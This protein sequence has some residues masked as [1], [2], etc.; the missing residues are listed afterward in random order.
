MKH[1]VELMGWIEE[2]LREVSRW[3]T[4]PNWSEKEWQ[5]EMKGVA[6]LAGWTAFCSHRLHQKFPRKSFV[7]G[8]IKAAL[9]QRYRE[10][11][12]FASRSH[13]CVQSSDD[14]VGEA[15]EM[16]VEEI[17]DVSAEMVF[18]WRVE[19]RDLLARL[20]PKEHY[21]LERLFIDGL[22][23]QEVANEL[24]ISQ[25]TVSR[26]KQEAIEKLKSM[27]VGECPENETEQAC[28]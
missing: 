11:W 13:P 5:E 16:P 7:K 22:T 4:P 24:G 3:K 9:L 23:E 17:A 2:C 20:G 18:W 15:D 21:L 12:R 1:P 27:L 10:E 19:V 26:W 8:R 25:P 14:N 28:E 6:L